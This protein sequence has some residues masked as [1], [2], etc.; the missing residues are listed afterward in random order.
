MMIVLKFFRSQWQVF[1][2]K[3]FLLFLILSLIFFSNRC[4]DLLFCFL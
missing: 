1:Q 3:S 4:F 2:C